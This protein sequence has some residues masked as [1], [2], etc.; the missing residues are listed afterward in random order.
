MLAGLLLIS[1]TLS[2]VPAE[3][4]TGFGIFAG[5]LYNLTTKAFA[6]NASGD[7]IGEGTTQSTNNAE[8][9]GPRVA[10]DAGTTQSTNNADGAAPLTE[11][12]DDLYEETTE[13][14]IS[15]DSVTASYDAY[16]KMDGW[17]G[18]KVHKASDKTYAITISTGATAGKSLLFFGI[19]YKAEDGSTRRQY[20]F[21]QVD[22][23]NR[24]EA[25]LNYYA[26]GSNITNTYGK[27]VIEKY[28][29]TE[30]VKP[31][32]SLDSWTTV[33]Y[34]FETEAVIKEVL[35]VEVY[36]ETG[37]VDSKTGEVTK[38]G[39]NGQGISI[40]KVNSYKGYEEY[41]LVSGQQF[42]DFEGYLIAEVQ[43]PTGD[44]L[45]TSGVDKMFVV[46]EGSN[47]NALKLTTYDNKSKVKK[48]SGEDDLYSIRLDIA[49]IY[50]AGI[51][52]F[53]NYSANKIGTNDNIM[54]NMVLEVQY[55]D[56]NNW[57][58]KVY[59]PVLLSA[60]G[61]IGE[62]LKGEVIYGFGLR[63]DT[64][65]FE[66]KLPGYKSLLSTTMYTGSMAESKLNENGISN[67]RALNSAVTGDSISLAGISIYQGGCMPYLGTGTA[68]DG[69]QYKC[70]TVEYLFGSSV[71]MMYY[72]TTD[73]KGRSISKNGKDQ[74]TM[75][76]YNSKN[77]L[78]AANS[79]EG[80]YMVTVKTAN[81]TG[82]GTNNNVNMRFY[83]TDSN[84]RQ[85]VT[86]YKSIKKSAANYMGD[87]K[88]D[89]NTDFISGSG[90]E[91]GGKVSYLLD[92]DDILSFVGMQASIDGGDVWIMDNVLISYVESYDKRRAYLKEETSGGLK[93]NFRLERNCVAGVV[94][95]LQQCRAVVADDSTTKVDVNDILHP[96][97]KKDDTDDEGT[98]INK[99]KTNGDETTTA[100]GNPTGQV[101]KFTGLQVF[102]NRT[103]TISFN[104]EE[105][106]DIRDVDYST[107]K[108]NMTYDQTSID[109]GFFKKRK[110]YSIGVNVAKDDIADL[111]NG[112]AGS[113]NHFYFQ[114]VF[115]NGNSAY[116]LANQQMTSD[117]FRSGVTERFSISTNQDYGA[118]KGIRIIPEDL[119]TAADPFDKLNIDSIDISEDTSGGCY[120]TYVIDDIGW[121]DIEY[122]D[123]E[124]KVSLRGRKGR[125]QNEIA[126]YFPLSYTTTSVKVLCEMALGGWEG[127]TPQFVGTVK[128]DVIYEDKNG[129]ER[130]LTQD[131]VRR[132][133]EYYEIKAS[134]VESTNGT[135]ERSGT[136]ADGTGYTSVPDWMFRPNHTDRFTLDPIPNLKR[137]KSIE[138][139]ATTQNGSPSVWNVKSFSL[140]QV[141][142]DGGLQHTANEELYRNMDTTPLCTVRTD[143]NSGSEYI[144][145]TKTEIGKPGSIGPI[146]FPDHEF[147]W[148]ADD[149][150]TPVTRMP[151]TTDDEFNIYVY[152]AVGS[153]KE[154]KKNEK[155]GS[156]KR[157]VKA[158]VDY[159]TPFSKLMTTGMKEMTLGTD[160]MGNVMYYAKGVNAKNTINLSKMNVSCS[161]NSILFN[162]AV[163]QHLRNGV[164]IGSY[165]YSL[166]DQAG[167]YGGAQGTLELYNRFSDDTEEDVFIAIDE[168]TKKQALVNEANDVAVS[169]FYTSTIDDVDGDKSEYQSP[170]IYL[171]DLGIYNISG[172]MFVDVHS[173]IPYVKEIT[174]YT[175]TAYGAIKGRVNGACA[176]VKNVPKDANGVAVSSDA[177]N[178]YAS[179][180]SYTSFN[181]CFDL[182]GKF[183]N[184]KATSHKCYGEN[185]VTPVEVTFNTSGSSMTLKDSKKSKISMNFN[186]TNYLGVTEAIFIDDITKFID[187]DTNR[188][189]AKET[190]T[191]RFFIPE[192]KDKMNITSAEVYFED[193][194]AYWT[195]D[196]VNV[197]FGLGADTIGRV[198][199]QIFRGDSDENIM[200]FN[201][202]KLTT[203]VSTKDDMVRVEDHE[204]S[205]VAYGGD[206]ITG[207]ANITGTTSKAGVEVKAYKM[208]GDTPDELKGD[209]LTST[210][211]TFKFSV[212]KN[213]TSEIVKYK[214]VVKAKD[215]PTIMDV[216]YITVPGKTSSSSSSDTD[217]TNPF[218]PPTTEDIGDGDPDSE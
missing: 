113:S 105:T 41:G 107:V 186:Y 28:N 206:V 24:T 129:V 35:S 110:T 214:I 77:P 182:S 37:G 116:V 21:P 118:I 196:D 167:T 70:S 103:Y 135:K 202:I 154:I 100:S 212:P 44:T 30:K 34:A 137:I 11:E 86:A 169:F 53:T 130:R 71:P 204:Y 188:F 64:I 27:S 7:N 46:G 38:S 144:E 150:V 177:A 199:E 88:T 195:I 17:N 140:S 8:G 43:N 96:S 209:E 87:W 108:Y 69:K 114:L 12:D 126:K 175:I 59:L 142:K 190:Q 4:V 72:T 85:Q 60:Y 10:D 211:N 146:V 210:K 180:R 121:I 141:L 56:V 19:R 2:Y 184:H 55:Q 124:E 52:E 94:F 89:N 15:P 123:E 152:P 134:A 16:N 109:W 143:E 65:A 173:K 170:Y 13:Y 128:A 156:K 26:D 178:S 75:I 162:H 23:Y 158:S 49:D 51:E 54:E 93:S 125:S 213:N 61:M 132:L 201:N 131:I 101:P 91:E 157:A 197:V 48:F 62:Q 98:G 9:G 112:D 102:P 174:G 25:M 198:G 95:E 58:R 33:D 139:I 73:D 68:T 104:S 36:M 187:N 83:Y 122:Y 166:F 179:Q 165:A 78:I 97:S 163:V 153:I 200:R 191:I 115:A 119:S 194:D 160:A 29:Y 203:D 67:N 40:Y 18:R 127:D 215:D 176:Q 138:L 1:F 117:G 161:D 22:A 168:D 80:R 32:T 185:G 57:T 42:L 31:V 172:G 207:T 111:G 151:D 39:W 208:V 5:K 181:R 50:G 106:L 205:F 136:N 148:E 92:E 133:A 164:V 6:A 171:T 47:T 14:R 82:A 193:E 155:L 159:D 216:I 84:G 120:V 218:T 81:E 217:T 147:V 183:T 76:K 90:L 145:S 99:K 74:I 45:S 79:G 3:G 20:V 189:V 149:I 66:G 192:M 63:G